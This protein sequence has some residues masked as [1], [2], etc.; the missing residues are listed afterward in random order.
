MKFVL[1]DKLNYIREQRKRE[2]K[3]EFFRKENP[4]DWRT[5]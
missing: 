5:N 2:V 3:Q 1:I 4:L